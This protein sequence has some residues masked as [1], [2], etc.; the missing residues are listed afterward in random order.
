MKATLKI[1]FGN[2]TCAS[3]KG[4][5]CRFMWSRN[6]GNEAICGLFNHQT[7]FNK[8]GW[9]MRCP[10]CLEKWPAKEEK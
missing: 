6:L 5:F 2:K 4:K 10:Q 3:E 1:E 8:D 7:L 9:L